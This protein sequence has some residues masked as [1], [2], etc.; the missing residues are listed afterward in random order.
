MSGAKSGASLTVNTGISRCSIRVYARSA[1]CEPFTPAANRPAP[2][3][4][5]D[6][7]RNFLLRCSPFA[8]TPC[9]AGRGARY[10]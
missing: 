4:A 7:G 1:L 10:K 3:T 2:L 5:E 8:R 6:K 9:A